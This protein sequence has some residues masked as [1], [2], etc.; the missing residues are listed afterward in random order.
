VTSI[1]ICPPS[2]AQL[3]QRLRGRG[4]DSEEV[5]NRRMRSAAQ[6]MQ[7]L[8][9]CDY[10]VVNDRLEDAVQDVQN[11]LAAERLLRARQNGVIQLGDSIRHSLLNS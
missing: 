11:I 2:A 7:H 1:F 3:E 9:S 10:A 4:T 6:E 8:N 5:I